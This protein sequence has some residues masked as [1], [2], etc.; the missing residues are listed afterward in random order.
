M[1]KIS[2]NVC[3]VERTRARRASAG[4]PAGG[5]ARAGSA[6]PDASEGA[7]ADSTGVRAYAGADLGA[8]QDTAM[9]AAPGFAM[10]V[11]SDAD[12]GASPG[13]ALEEGPGFAMGVGSDADLGA[14]SDADLGADP[15]FA[16]GAAQ[17]TDLE[18]VPGFAL[19]AATDA[20][21]GTGG[22]LRFDPIRISDKPRF[23]ALFKAIQPQISDFTFSNLLMWRRL[24]KLQA[25]WLGGFAVILA[26]PRRYPPYM[27]APAGDM[28]D[29][30]GFARAA[31][32]ACEHFRAMGWEPCFRCVPAN[33]APTLMRV[34]GACG[35]D[36]ACEPDRDFFDYVYKSE[37]LIGLRG[38]RF[39]GKRN[40]I[41]RFKRAYSFEYEEL[42]EAHIGECARVMRDRCV[43]NDCA[44]LGGAFDA[45]DRIPSM[46]L[47]A[48]FG[49]LDCQGAAIRV[50]GR[51]EAFTVGEALNDD[52]A[53]IY[54]EKANI[55]IHGLYAFI[56]QQFCERAWGG[57]AYVNREED[58]G[59]E[60][61]RRAKLSYHPARLVEKFT[62]SC[63]T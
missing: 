4:S 42:T 5:R 33:V 48:H 30:E 58:E 45:C 52:T 40:H 43:E 23:N 20:A 55:A 17:D 44:C 38:K 9:G 2:C 63:K 16:L 31:L 35:F 39:D 49:E 47:L 51:V 50:G 1:G 10:G 61:L 6:P 15:G 41:S 29:E 34:M 56:N 54:I 11:G 32:L 13:A 36:A 14:A 19:G 22:V 25:C 27:Y 18:I 59:I 24:I 57:M 7:D 60:G 53:V 62:V 46:E 28:A 8:A 26:I 12:L 3:C 37:D 21:L